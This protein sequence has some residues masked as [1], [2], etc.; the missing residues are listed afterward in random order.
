VVDPTGKIRVIVIEAT[1]DYPLLLTA[2]ERAP[3]ME[4]EWIRNAF[5]A[6]ERET[7]FWAQAGDFEQFE[8]GLEADP[9]VNLVRSV[10]LGQRRLYQAT[11]TDRGV[12][13]DLYPVVVDVGG[14]I[15]SATATHEGW[16]AR[17]AFPDQAAVDQYF[18]TSVQFDVDFD[19]ERLTELDRNGADSPFG[20]TETQRETLLTALDAGYFDVP[21]ET[22]LAELA[23]SLGVSEQAVSERIRRGTKSLVE[24]VASADDTEE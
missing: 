4:V 21:R 18:E 17:I 24:R 22:S 9:T 7:L 15:M 19:I 12:E 1:F 14:M 16:R 5:P 8:S 10:D 6:E 23:D 3:E 11:L 2:L 13:T 20:L